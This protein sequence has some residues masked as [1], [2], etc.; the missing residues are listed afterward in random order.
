MGG[1]MSQAC[2]PLPNIPSL[3]L[4]HM[5]TP[6]CR[7]GWELSLNSVPKKKERTG[8]RGDPEVSTTLP[9]LIVIKPQVSLVFISSE[10]KIKKLYIEIWKDP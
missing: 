6:H 1:F 7:G 4:G 3:E 10:K 9:M 2:T 8:L 5:A